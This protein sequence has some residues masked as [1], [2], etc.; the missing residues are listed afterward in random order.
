[1]RLVVIT[2]V[3]IAVGTI[4]VLYVAL[5]YVSKWVGGFLLVIGA[6]NVLSY[7]RTGRRAFASMR[8]KHPFAAWFWVHIGE[9][10][11]QLLF[12]GIGIILAIAGCILFIMESA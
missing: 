4:C 8:S 7:R 9:S 3:V 11:S 2:L 12:L 6:L 5:P 1:M 10:G